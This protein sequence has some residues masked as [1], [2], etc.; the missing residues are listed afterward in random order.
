MKIYIR[1]LEGTRPWL[2]M[3]KPSDEWFEVHDI[4]LFYPP[5]LPQQ[6]IFTISDGPEAYRVL[7]TD[8]SVIRTEQEDAYP[9]PV[10]DRRQPN[11]RRDAF[12]AAALTGLLNHG[13]AINKVLAAMAWKAAD[14]M[15]E[16]WEQR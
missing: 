14:E 9:R 6:V 1:L 7:S 13:C 8:V 4:G 10:A 12:A 2:A 5:A 3:N 15:M 16:H 11:A